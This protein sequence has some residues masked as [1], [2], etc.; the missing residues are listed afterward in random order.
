MKDLLGKSAEVRRTRCSICGTE[1]VLSI[2]RT[3]GDAPCPTCGSLLWWFRQRL[4]EDY[5]VAA[6]QVTPATSFAADLGTDSVDLC[7]LALELEQEFKL[8]I[9]DR[10]VQQM[11]TVADAIRYVETHRGQ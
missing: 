11:K 1:M 7:E 4:S 2:V 10:D 8:E 6:D 5:G 9:P 3:S